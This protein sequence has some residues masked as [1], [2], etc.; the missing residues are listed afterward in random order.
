M[1][2]RTTFAALLLLAA[3]VLVALV[4]G[5]DP[6]AIARELA[7]ADLRLI[8][9]V[10]LLYLGNTVLKVAR[11]YLLLREREHP[12]PFARVGL[13]FLIGL[14]V[15]N[16]LPGHIAGEPVRAYLLKK[17]HD[18]PMGRAMASIFL[19][20]TIDTVVTIVLALAGVLLLVNVLQRSLTTTL[21][22]FTGVIA[23]LMGALILF[24]AYPAGPRRLARWAFVKLRRRWEE[25]RVTRYESIIDGFL[26]TF[27][28]GTRSISHDRSR[29]A[30]ATALTVVIWLN[31][32]LRLWLVF[33]ALGH[34]VAAE[35][36][37]VA[38][39]ISSF[40]AL[41]VPIG[42]G[43][44]ATIAV[45][46]GL[47]GVEAG[48]AA[49]ASLLHIM[50]SIWISAPM[51]MAAMAYAGVTAGELLGPPTDMA[52]GGGGGGGSGGGDGGAGGDGEGPSSG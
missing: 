29:A 52:G 44:S 10:V 31:E 14:A 5:G 46:C 47:A 3:L 22:A 26:G 40:A 42:A 2:R 32:A 23:L 33:L 20:K 28:E 16:S 39:T 24:V 45:I 34:N 17:G 48:V 8:G 13:Y 19:E 27:E 18:Y 9:A 51:G 35:L 41:L 30:T 25:S 50:T 36:V 21:L 15:N 6:K 1:R 7:K 12:L 38:A 37:L 4:L 43:N 11:W 49:S